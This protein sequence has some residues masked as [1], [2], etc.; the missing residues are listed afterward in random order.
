MPGE[1]RL[2]TATVSDASELTI[3]YEGLGEVSELVGGEQG[4]FLVRRAGHAAKEVAVIFNHNAAADLAKELGV[5]NDLAF[6]QGA[7]RDI[8]RVAI[9]KMFARFGRLDSILIVSS[10]SLREDPQLLAEAR[11][12]FPMPTAAEASAEHAEAPHEGR[13]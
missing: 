13:Y 2:S 4:N 3:S 7:V 12:L 1:P 9:E 10:G 8:G 5:T 11:R 6:Q